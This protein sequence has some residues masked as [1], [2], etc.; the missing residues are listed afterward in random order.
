[1]KSILVGLCGRIPCSISRRCTVA[2]RA[3]V[4][5]TL[6]V[7]LQAAERL[8]LRLLQSRTGAC[9]SKAAYSRH[10]CFDNLLLPW[11]IRLCS[12]GR[13][14]LRGSETRVHVS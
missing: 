11:H 13:A 6:W 12:V 3:R 7:M 8:P 14:T 5:V 10:R 1:M 4:V 9:A 2:V